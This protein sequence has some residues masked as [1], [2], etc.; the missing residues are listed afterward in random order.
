MSLETLELPTDIGKAIQNALRSGPDPTL[1][2]LEFSEDEDCHERQSLISVSSEATTTLPDE[3][4]VA[5]LLWQT[6]MVMERDQ[7]FT[8]DTTVLRLT[9][10]DIFEA[11]WTAWRTQD[12]VG[13]SYQLCLADNTVFS[14][15]RT[16]KNRERPLVEWDGRL[17][18]FGKLPA[19]RLAGRRAM[20][21]LPPN[22]VAT[23]QASFT[24]SKS[25]DF[26]DYNNV[27]FFVQKPN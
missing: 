21:S 10:P 26:F 19:D 3:M 6:Q 11:L 18:P 22:A 14:G 25:L 1:L 2:W 9:V 15:Q 7:K 8:S 17:A 24:G 12:L 4:D 5:S 27:R 23:L 16:L 20:A 13:I